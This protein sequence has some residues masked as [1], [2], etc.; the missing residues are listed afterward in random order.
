MV[1]QNILAK[2]F[3]PCRPVWRKYIADVP[4]Y[5][6]TFF[7]VG[8]AFRL[9]SI[10][11]VC[12]GISGF[13]KSLIFNCMT[14]FLR[15]LSSSGDR[16]KDLGRVASVTG[17][18]FLLFAPLSVPAQSTQAPQGPVRIEGR[19]IDA[20]S[21]LLNGAAVSV[22]G[23]DAKTITDSRGRFTISTPK[24]PIIDIQVSFVG[25]KTATVRYTGQKLLNIVLQPDQ[26]NLEEVVV[27]GYQNVDRRHLTSAVSSVKMDQIEIPSLVSV[28]QM[29]EGRVP[30]LMVL[31]NTGQVGT[32][33]KIR[34]RGTSSVL[35]NQ[36]PLWVVDGIIQQDPVNVPASS[37]NDLD[38][39]NLVGN[40]ISGLN[41]DDIDRIDVLKD[42]A[43]TALYGARAANGVIVVTTKKGTSGPPRVSYTFNGTF[44]RR[45]HYTD[46]YYYMMNSQQRVGVS[47][48]MLENGAIYNESDFI[49]YERAYLDFY[50]DGVINYNEYIRQSQYYETLNTDWL[51]YLTQNAFTQ[52]HSVSLSG[53]GDNIGYYVSAGYANE[54]GNVRNEWNKRYSSAIKINGN[55]NRLSFQF[56][57]NANVND[58]NYTPASVDVMKYATTMNRAIPLYGTDGELWYYK[59]SNQPFNIVNEMN[60][61]DLDIAQESAV[62]SGQVN[63]KFSDAFK[64]QAVGSYQFS[65]TDEDEW[66][67]EDSW[68][69]ANLRG[70]D[71]SKAL[72]PWG[73][74]LTYRK[75]RLRAWSARLQADYSKYF[76]GDKHFVNV[77]AG[78]ELSSSDYQGFNL[79]TYG[80][81]RGRGDTY[82][83]PPEDMS[84]Y[85]AYNKFLSLN[86]PKLSKQLTNMVSFY[87]TWTY[88]YKD[89]YILNFNTRADWSNAFG[90][91]SNE[92]LFPVWSISGRWNMSNDVLKDVKWIDNAALKLSYGLQGN[93]LNDQPVV[94]TIKKEGYD[95][96]YQS[97]V[98]KL[99]KFANPD[100]KWEKTHS[101][102]IG[103]DFSIFNQTVNGS[104]AYYYKKT[105]DAFLPVEVA[106]QNGVDS[107]TVNKGTIENKGLDLT[108]N[109]TPINRGV[110]GGKQGFVWR[111]DPQLGQVINRLVNQS[112]NSGERTAQDGLKLNDLLSG[113]AQIPG[114]ALNTFYSFRFAGLDSQGYPTFYGLN[115]G[116]TALTPEQQASYISA[117]MNKYNQIADA[118]EVSDVWFEYLAKS[119]RRV[120]TLQGGL[121]NYF[122]YRNFSLSFNFTYSVGSKIRQLKLTSWDSNNA[123]GNPDTY[124]NLRREWNDRWRFEG[125]ETWTNIPRLIPYLN[126]ANNPLYYG[127]WNK[128]EATWK[129]NASAGPANTY[130]MYD[131][132]DYRVV[133]G[134]YLRLSSV[135]LRYSFDKKLLKHINVSNAYVSFSGSN[136]F[137]ICDRR[138]KGQ[139]PEQS[140]ATDQVNISMRPRYTCTLNLTF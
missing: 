28:D 77:M 4:G 2:H 47:E 79:L 5:L 6:K 68:H 100:L 134:D 114:V 73:G 61:S 139:S 116:L 9:L 23:T 34:I 14:G 130:I 109:F 48:E 32:S 92:N 44:M 10:P 97:Y 84:P 38:F 30:G 85:T 99:D 122:A 54:N 120:P 55:Y 49:G 42:A 118:G 16:M 29:L 133:S 60:N 22:K 52:T 59:K 112:I 113:R 117:L 41:P 31:N 136:L 83:R 11:K 19:V 58:K 131:N 69:V 63:Y 74:E 94:M 137:T 129:P 51:K 21:V 33:P 57:V 125:D 20:D 80:Y 98:S 43:A 135:Q 115:N 106:S 132:S 65:S 138:L 18:L 1:K 24:A 13:S 39:V 78:Y 128:L 102:N 108:L 86:N 123:A 87:T 46:K 36:E 127:W 104:I 67:G 45:P 81:Q 88:A 15:L 17:L 110:S 27:M 101:Y 50:R 126:D 103:L 121:N 111:F 7:R 37:L 96:Y 93:M 72:C 3:I 56:G 76:C 66:Y 53:A 107:Y 105:E 95:S 26:T 119:G 25:Y 70:D 124:N 71:A 62:F 40:A 75:T 91:R 8:G 90:S 82:A 35:G 140:G 64:M 89:R 12:E